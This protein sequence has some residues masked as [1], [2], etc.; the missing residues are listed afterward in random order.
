M[1]VRGG[2]IHETLYEPR[3]LIARSLQP[4]NARVVAVEEH[5]LVELIEVDVRRSTRRDARANQRFQVSPGTRL[6][7]QNVQRE[8]DES[9]PERHIG[10]I[11]RFG[12][13]GAELLAE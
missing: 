11:G 13:D 10:T 4:E 1:I 5:S 8:T 7:S 12:G 9:T 3:R 2:V 6:I